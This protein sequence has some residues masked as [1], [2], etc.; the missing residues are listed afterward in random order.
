MGVE[1]FSGETNFILIRCKMPN[2]AKKLINKGIIIKDLSGDWL[3]GFYRISI[4]LPEEND[5]FLSEISSIKSNYDP[6]VY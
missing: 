5:A 2:L 3:D 4:G 1:V 6:F